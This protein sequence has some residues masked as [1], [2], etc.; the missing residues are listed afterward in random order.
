MSNVNKNKMTEHRWQHPLANHVKTINPLFRHF[1]L[2][3]NQN[4]WHT[5]TFTVFLSMQMKIRA[6][7]LVLLLV[8]NS[9]EAASQ[10]VVSEASATDGWSTADG[11]T[12]DWIEL[13]NDG[14]TAVNL[15]GHR[16][17]DE[18]DFESGWELP[19][20]DLLPGQRLLIL[21]SG[22]DKSYTPSN[23]QC[24]ALESD[25]WQYLVPTSNPSAN[26]K[27]PEFDASNWNTGPGGFGYA[28]GD[29]AT[30]LDADIIFLRRSFD[31]DDPLDWGYLSAAVDYDDGYIAYL[32]GN[33]ISRSASMA[34][35]MGNFNDYANTWIEANLYQGIV[36]EQSIW[37]DS[38]FSSW[39]I[40]GENV[41]AVQVHNS[42]PE[43]SDLSIRP[44]LGLTRKDGLDT[45]WPGPPAWWPDFG[46][47]MHTSFQLSPGE[48]VVW[49]NANG[50]V[51]DALP[52]HPDLVFG[53]SVGRPEGNQS[54]WCIFDSPTPGDENDD[55]TC[56]DGFQ[57]NAG[58][59]QPSGWYDS[60]L[61]VQLDNQNSDQ[62]VRY[63][64]N[65]DYPT[66][67]DAV[68]PIAGLEFETST[69]LSLRAWNANGTSIP[70]EVNDFTYIIDEFTPQVPTFSIITDE[71]HLWDWNTG[72]YVDGPN[73]GP[74][75]PYFGSNFWEPWSRF[76]RLEYFDANGTSLLKEQL[77][78]EIHGGW[79]R[80]E[81]QRSFRLDFRGE[82][83]G[84]FDYP[85]FD[86]TPE[87]T[88]FN[89]LNLRNGGQHS[90]ATKL[91]DAM[92][93]RMARKTHILAS[94]WRPAILYL[95]GEFWGLYG[96]R[97]KTDEHF[98]ANEFLVDKDEVDLL[99]PTAVLNGSD[100]DFLSG[101]NSLLAASPFST[102]FLTAFETHFDVNNY[103]DY[104]VFETYAQNTDWLG[105]AWQLN[106]IKTFRSAPDQPW[107]Y[108]MYDTDA[109]F[110][111]F[112][113][114][115]NDNFIDWAR[116]PGSPNI[117]SNLFD[118]VLLNTAFR[119]RFINRYA[120]LINTMFQ[121]ANFNAA[122]S[123]TANMMSATMPPHIDRWNSPAS[124][125]DWLNAIGNL[126]D[127][128]SSRV[129]TS[130]NHLMSSFDLPNDFN[131][132]LDVFPPPAGNV[133]V[134]TI[135]PGPLPWQGIYF[136]ACPIELEALA[137][138][139]WMFD[140]WSMNEHIQSGDM[141]QNMRTTT[142][143][144]FMD[145]LFRARF[146]PCPVDA[147]AM[148]ISTEGILSL[149]LEN[150]P[151]TDSIAW[152]LGESFVGS[153]LDWVPNI[154]GSYSAQIFFDGCSATAPAFEAGSVDI[155]LF[156]ASAAFKIWP[157]PARESFSFKMPQA[158]P[159]N[160][161]NSL[162]QRIWQH[163][164]NATETTGEV[165]VQVSTNKWPEGTYVVRSGPNAFKL[166]IQR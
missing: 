50:E 58:A 87:I 142:V 100:Q 137:N 109:G 24:P 151:Y 159:F 65:G 165:V 131:C 55:A 85:I 110:G 154:A 144:L 96:V 126:T 117:H 39:L 32:N 133:R 75:Y 149:A 10:L 143:P 82:Y 46:S 120:D 145:D 41:F 114:S 139:G 141:S 162:G 73:A 108:L 54:D 135:T 63:T 60:P 62:I 92:Y 1:N 140:S 166:V 90:W 45:A 164:G 35:V 74:D 52:L 16:L 123:E 47:L 111:F 7:Y 106:N 160:V 22:D 94:N 43:S 79:S 152:F 40:E 26:W 4:L 23:W 103:I 68:F 118:K 99:S 49:F 104:F 107:R 81:P 98:I 56:Y 130:R 127:H 66:A 44:F 91:Q 148:I 124:Y 11:S 61:A 101:A 77:D 88:S 86:D 72:I 9:I 59:T 116:N 42:G 48:A 132:T 20:L 18:F 95:N 28:D 12:S 150:I 125:G 156:H 51:E 157:N 2:H 15:L 6:Q 17:N 93:S 89:N 3:M 146:A 102:S 80:A 30:E 134:N 33:E 113:A 128:N 121:S 19:A 29:D 105:L 57:E 37:D 8:L 83:T 53:L 163:S 71:D 122:V 36:P 67:T 84:D 13:R 115:V 138:D 153:G 25:E 155:D 14:S 70:S 129:N 112:G 34:G 97:Q 161:F 78:L 119:L 64:T 136:E 21:A 31:I 76:S 158:K 27:L 69:V 5:K 38:Q 147:S